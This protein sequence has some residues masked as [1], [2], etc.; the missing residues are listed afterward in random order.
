MV[1][2]TW[3]LRGSRIRSRQLA[4]ALEN[5]L[6]DYLLVYLEFLQNESEQQ[7]YPR[8]QVQGSLSVLI[9]IQV[10]FSFFSI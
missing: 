9:L 6:D 2:P 7:T 5:F 1:S 8:S 4:N 10:Y 3:C